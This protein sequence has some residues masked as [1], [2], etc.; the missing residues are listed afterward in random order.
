MAWN[1]YGGAVLPDDAAAV[2][3]AAGG[4]AGFTLATGGAGSSNAV[5]NSGVMAFSSDAASTRTYRINNVA[6]SGGTYPKYL[7]LLAKVQGNATTRGLEIE[8]TISEAASKGGRY[9]L[10]IQQ[11]SSSTARL[12][13]ENYNNVSSTHLDDASVDSGADN[14]YQINLTQISLTTGTITVYANGVAVSTMNYT[15][16]LRL[17]STNGDNYIQFGDSSTT[18]GVTNPYQSSIDWIIW[19]NEFCSAGACTPAQLA[20]RLPASLGVVS[21]Y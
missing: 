3:L 4:T 9:K 11:G 15:G 12:R 21:G 19:T 10:I 2:A 5:V 20:G 7:T 8:G 18:A 14:V 13:L 6:D 1:V 17:A 16:A